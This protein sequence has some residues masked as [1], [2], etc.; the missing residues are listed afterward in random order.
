MNSG[1]PIGIESV[2]ATFNDMQYVFD[3]MSMDIGDMTEMLDQF[4]GI[5]LSA[6]DLSIDIT[7][8]ISIPMTL[9]LNLIGVKN[10]GVD[11]MVISKTQQI[12]GV[13]GDPHLVFVGAADLINFQPDSLLF[14]GNISIDGTGNMPLTQDISIAG[15][16][17]VPFQ[18]T[19]NEPISFPATYSKF[20]LPEL[21]LFLDDYSGSIKADINNTYQFG[22]DF[23]MLTASDTNYFNNVA[24]EDCVRTFV[25]LTIPALDTTTQ[26]IV[27]T[28][29]LY[30]YYSLAPDSLWMMMDIKLSGRN[31]GEPTTFLSTD[32]VTMGL[33]IQADGT[34]DISELLADTTGID[35]TGGGQ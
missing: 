7:S 14:N 13:G 23:A 30:E 2:D 9:D 24:Y 29:E 6:I 19:I 21:P 34:L 28:K 18:F 35:T 11:S 15:N 8:A 31:D 10:A 26:N 22:V 27:L 17:G 32:Y 25:E 5:E 1:D 3:E 20:G 4:A 33:T 12:T 16:I